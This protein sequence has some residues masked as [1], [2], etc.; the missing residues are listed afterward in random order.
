MRSLPKLIP[1]VHPKL[2]GDAQG[3]VKRVYSHAEEHR[4]ELNLYITG[5]EEMEEESIGAPTGE[6]TAES[7]VEPEPDEAGGR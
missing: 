6:P 2:P 1:G 4:E 7:A 3:H 5:E